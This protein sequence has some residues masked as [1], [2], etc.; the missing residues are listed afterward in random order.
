M[1]LYSSVMSSHVF[2]KAQRGK[3]VSVSHKGRDKI[4][5]PTVLQQIYIIFEAGILGWNPNCFVEFSLGP[6]ATSLNNESLLLCVPQHHIA[7]EEG[8]CS[9]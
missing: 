5:F 8:G 2:I 7:H 4:D 6:S 3:T 9:L 1:V